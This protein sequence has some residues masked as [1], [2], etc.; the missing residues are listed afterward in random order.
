MFALL[1]ACLNV[2][3]V[4][5][6]DCG[7]ITFLTIAIIGKNETMASILLTGDDNL[8]SD[9]KW[10]AL[11][12][13][14]NCRRVVQTSIFQVPHHGARTNWYDGLADA[15]SPVLSVSSSDPNHKVDQNS[16]FSLHMYLETDRQ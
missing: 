14:L 5:L 2:I 16:D 10:N 11:E 7:S 15:A 1:S 9:S 4:R 8:G 3:W 12:Q 6:D 13:Y